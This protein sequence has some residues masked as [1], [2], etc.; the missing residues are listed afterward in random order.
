MFFPDCAAKECNDIADI[1]VV[2]VNSDQHPPRGMGRR[3]TREA[4]R[5]RGT[6]NNFI[7]RAPSN[8]SE[9][10]S[11]SATWPGVMP[12]IGKLAEVIANAQR[13]AQLR[14]T[15]TSARGGSPRT[16]ARTNRDR[17]SM[18]V[19]TPGRAPLC[20]APAFAR[21][22]RRRCRRLCPTLIVVALP[23]SFVRIGPAGNEGIAADLICRKG[24]RVRGTMRFASF[25]DVTHA[26]GARN[27]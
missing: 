17:S 12:T 16:I 22:A 21:Q 4:H 10:P 6:K 24:Q 1:R 25:G 9:E 13:R 18:P 3:R 26:G 2:H 23:S 14:P 7:R 8:I 20:E 5:V 27:R 19:G 15:S 11:D